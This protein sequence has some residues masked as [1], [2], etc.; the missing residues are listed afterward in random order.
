MPDQLE[1]TKIGIIKFL[2]GGYF[3]DADILAHLIIAASDTR[4]AVA[5][6][7]DAELRKIVRFVLMAFVDASFIPI[8][9]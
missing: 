7:A 9:K 6:L 1:Q 3:P 5:N 4:F 8:D 2:G